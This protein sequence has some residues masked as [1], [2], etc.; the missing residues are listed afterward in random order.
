MFLR[1]KGEY[2]TGCSLRF[3]YIILKFTFREKKISFLYLEIQTLVETIA[4]LSKI[5]KIYTNTPN[6]VNRACRN[7]WLA[8]RSLLKGMA[9]IL[10]KPREHAAGVT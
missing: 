1:V 7:Q 3:H 8:R 9:I 10:N 2:V 6:A 5:K 4:S